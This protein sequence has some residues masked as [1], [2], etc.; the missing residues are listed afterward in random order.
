[1]H[2]VTMYMVRHGQTVYNQTGRVQGW[3]DSSLTDEGRQ[4]AVYCGRGL[5]DISF[6]AAYASDLKRAAD[7]AQVILDENKH[8]V[9]TLYER[10][11]LREIS[12]GHFD[13]GLNADR[14]SKSAEVLLGEAN[15]ELL[16][17]KLSTKELRVR[18]LLNAT[19]S[20]DESGTAETFE[21]MQNRAVKEIERIFR[22][23]HE[24]GMNNIL[25]VSHGV[26]IAS[27]LDFF[28]GAE[29]EQ[30]SDVK[31]ASVSRLIYDGNDIQVEEVASM[32]PAEEG[33]KHS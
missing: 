23:A 26:T 24:E 22:Q 17:E 8:D 32:T 2:T 31:N 16:N 33:K 7:T 1:M 10:E 25:I 14:I 21:Q 6:D 28:P 13:G 15:I 27:I 12:F 20:I 29:I 11:M 18:H 4:V 5:Q 9:P 30:I 3:K 19:H